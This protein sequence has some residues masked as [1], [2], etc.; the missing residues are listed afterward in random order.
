MV[1][2]L[3]SALPNPESNLSNSRC[4]CSFCSAARSPSNDSSNS[5][6]TDAF[7]VSAAAIKLSNLASDKYYINAL[8]GLETPRW[9][10]A[11]SLGTPVTLTYSFM[12][13]VPNYYTV[14]NGVINLSSIRTGT[15]FNAIS[16]ALRQQQI[17]VALSRW[18]DV[19][20]ITFIPAT[21]GVG[22]I[23]FGMT[24]ISGD[25]VGVG[26]LPN[27]SNSSNSSKGGDIWL[28]NE[29]GSGNDSFALGTFGYQT[30][31][32]ELGHALGL[33]HPFDEGAT[34]SGA[35]NSFKYTNMAYDY[36]AQMGGN[37]NRVEPTTA[38]LYDIAAI[39]Y[40]YGQ[41]REQDQVTITTLGQKTQL[42]LKRSGMG[43]VR[44]RS[45]PATKLVVSLS[46]SCRAI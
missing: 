4:G 32:H 25:A 13:A 3:S 26:F 1:V 30:V 38:L 44:T 22:Q 28:D 12:T 37:T 14:T 18:S 45:M 8:T 9:N 5:S 42:L 16:D 35:E 34:L 24:N 17:R 40:L 23:A 39:Q 19:A 36:H 33:K 43:V 27:S 31:F 46:I 11:S 2:Q 41:I 6:K 7:S 20:N 21:N 15:G 10:A 29:P